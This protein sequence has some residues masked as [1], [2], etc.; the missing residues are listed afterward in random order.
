M[1]P[2]PMLIHLAGAGLLA[3]ALLHLPIARR[4]RWREE[5]AR[6][7]EV[8]ASIF[9]VHTFFLVLILI[10]MGLPA[11]LEPSVFLERTRAGLWATSS[12]TVFWLCRLVAQWTVYRQRWWKG[13]PL[14][15]T[16]HWVFTCVWLA[17][18]LLFG[19]CAMRQFGF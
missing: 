8:N 11:L 9:H 2:L 13:R 19:A 17:L 7:S 5:A 10:A 1:I 3:L 12:I 16:V 18:V 15:T 6:M 14:E 4:L